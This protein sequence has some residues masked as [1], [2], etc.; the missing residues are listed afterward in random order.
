MLAS[1]TTD[2]KP[3]IITQTHFF[4]C[5]D[6]RGHHMINVFTKHWTAVVCHSVV[7]R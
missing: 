1:A 2:Y 4:I 6:T 5:S 7:N 3:V